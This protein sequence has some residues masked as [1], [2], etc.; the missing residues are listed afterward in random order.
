MHAMFMLLVALLWLLPSPVHALLHCFKYSPFVHFAQ[1]RLWLPRQFC[2]CSSNTDH[3]LQQGKII[4]H[5]LNLCL[6]LQNTFESNGRVISWIVEVLQGLPYNCC[7]WLS[8]KLVL[9]LCWQSD[10][11][12]S[13]SQWE[14]NKNGKERGEKMTMTQRGTQT[15]NLAKVPLPCSN[16]QR[17]WVTRQLSGWVWVLMAELP[18]SSRSIYQ[19]ACSMGRVQQV[20]STRCIRLSC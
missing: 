4:P 11:N 12:L 3:R 8:Y 5:W 15:C 17:Y 16:Q 6:S 9:I 2:V 13:Q 18:G 1:R 19:V 14:R 20:Q 7:N 10:L